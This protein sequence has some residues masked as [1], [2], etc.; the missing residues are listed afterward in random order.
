MKSWCWMGL[1][2]WTWLHLWPRG[3]SLN[4]RSLWWPP[5]TKTILAW[6]RTLL[7]PSSRSLSLFFSILIY[8]LLRFFFFLNNIISSNFF[9]L[10]PL[11]IFF[12]FF[13]WWDTKCV[14]LK[15]FMARKGQRFQSIIKLRPLQNYGCELWHSGYS[16]SMPYVK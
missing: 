6:T 1:P 5:S 8:V 15:I 2:R 11:K 9:Q 10:V 3:W 13:K 16:F 14:L 12:F 4:A 7:P